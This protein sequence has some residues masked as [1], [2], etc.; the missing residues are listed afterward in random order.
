MLVVGPNSPIRVGKDLNG[1]TIAGTAVTSV[2]TIA[3][4]SWI[5]AHGG[6]SSTVKFVELPQ[7]AMGDA[8]ASGRIEAAT[9]SEPAL[10]DALAAGKVRNLGYAYGAI[11][12]RVMISGIFSTEEWANKH[13]DAY[14][15]FA[16]RRTPPR[17]GAQSGTGRGDL[18]QVHETLD[19]ARLRVPCADARSGPDPTGA[20]RRCA[21][22]SARA[23]GRA[24]DHLKG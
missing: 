19:P 14:E 13:A 15:K 8:V 24:R 5:D 22:V 17:G 10:G 16:R 2:D 6:D 18:A 21:A 20:G 9:I 3:A 23:D 11:A 12:K 1:K 7:G 4:Y